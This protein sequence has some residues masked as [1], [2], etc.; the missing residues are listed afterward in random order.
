MTTDKSATLRILHDAVRR[1]AV[2]AGWR[3]A[4][5]AQFNVFRSLGVSH[6]EQP[7]SMFL[8]N[9][10]DPSGSHGQGEL[11]L[12]T[13]LEFLEMSP[14][15]DDG[16]GTVVIVEQDVRNVGRWDILIC[17]RDGR[18]IVIENKILS[19]EQHLQVERYQRPLIASEADGCVVFLTPTGRAATSGSADRTKLLSYTQ[20]ADIVRRCVCRIEPPALVSVLTQYAAIC[21]EIGGSAAGGNMGA[22]DPE[23]EQFVANPETL[24]A[25]LD[26][27]PLVE[28]AKAGVIERFLNRLTDV[29]RK[30]LAS[31]QGWTVERSA[32]REEAFS[33][34][35]I[36]PAGRLADDASVFV[37]LL[38]RATRDPDSDVYIG[39]PNVNGTEV[40]KALL[41]ALR[42]AELTRTNSGWPGWAALTH[43]ADG[44]PNGYRS[45]QA[46]DAM[47]LEEVSPE[48][49][50]GLSKRLGRRL[51][52]CFLIC[53]DALEQANGA[54]AARGS[55]S[56]GT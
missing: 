42:S 12:R 29:V 26:L 27:Q 56:R 16:R 39:V 41:S 28:N 10:V 2:Q 3:R 13:F 24:R 22:F 33:P 8:A 18:R 35:V 53:R 7:H 17:L 9:L 25:L 20:L 4:T 46:L 55:K 15:L 31:V 5:A 19:P 34:V 6:R 54:I 1:H 45:P 30:E 36:R 23:V 47:L 48:D 37:M 51:A 14:P 21:D 43:L 49:A 44:F 11:F 40:S 32:D 50:N 38:A 52:R